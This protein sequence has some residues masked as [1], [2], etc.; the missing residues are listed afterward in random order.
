MIV[1]TYDR[2]S[3]KYFFKILPYWHLGYNF[4]NSLKVENDMKEKGLYIKTHF[5]SFNTV[6]Y[7]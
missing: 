4:N 3:R 1:V 2:I 6:H 7:Y 5:R